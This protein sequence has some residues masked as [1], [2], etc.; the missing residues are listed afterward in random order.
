MVKTWDG[1]ASDTKIFKERAHA[2]IEQLG[3][4]DLIEYLIADSKL[5]TAD[6]GRAQK[7]I[8][9]KIQAEADAIIF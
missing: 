1:N 3:N 4:T 7:R 9:K 2:I 8:E 5:Y 6:N